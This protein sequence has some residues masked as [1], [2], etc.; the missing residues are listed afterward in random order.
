MADCARTRS[1]PA[2]RRDALRSSSWPSHDVYVTIAY[3]EE[4]LIM[5]PLNGRRTSPNVKMY[6][7]NVEYVVFIRCETLT[8]LVYRYQ[9]TQQ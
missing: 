9:V 4:S 6:S 7:C 3:I 1:I 8:I 5:L 2:A